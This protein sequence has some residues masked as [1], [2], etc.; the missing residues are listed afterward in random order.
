MQSSV[1]Q[2]DAAGA[3]GLDSEGLECLLGLVGQSPPLA[4]YEAVACPDQAVRL[5]LYLTEH[6]LKLASP[7][8]EPRAITAP[9]VRRLRQL[10]AA[11]FP[12]HLPEPPDATNT[13]SSG[14]KPKP[15]AGAGFEAARLYASL[16]EFKQLHM[17]N[18]PRS[19][20]KAPLRPRQQQQARKLPELKLT[21]RQY[22]EEALE[23]MVCREQGRQYFLLADAA[24]PEEQEL[25]HGWVRLPGPPGEGPLYYN[26]ITVAVSKDPPPP[27]DSSHIRGGILADEMVGRGRVANDD[28]VDGHDDDD[29]GRG[30]SPGADVEFYGGSVVGAGAWQDHRGAK[31]PQH[32]L[33]WR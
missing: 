24:R 25:P 22:Q 18:G 21:L 1:L 8:N 5:D 11:L 19:K 30:G 7:T 32:G 2:E 13:A 17:P 33:K 6:A 12:H 26:P 28:D 29:D 10:M 31:D 3:L 14:K 23:W 27:F 4:Y 16:E 20:G 15:K 9:V